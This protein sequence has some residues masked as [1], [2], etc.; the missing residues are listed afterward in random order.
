MVIFTK[1]Q[2]NLAN[3]L[4]VAI[5]AQHVTALEILASKKEIRVG[6]TSGVIILI[7]LTAQDAKQ[8]FETLTFAC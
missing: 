8:A 6:L 4:K 7:F 5:N 3:S 2:N 1:E